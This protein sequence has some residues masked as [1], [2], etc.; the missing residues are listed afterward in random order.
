M[1]GW[2]FIEGW[3]D[4]NGEIELWRDGVIEG[5]RDGVIEEWSDRGTD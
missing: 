1:E 5:W 3:G 2:D 4:R